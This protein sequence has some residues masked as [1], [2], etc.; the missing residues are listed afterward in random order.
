MG[1]CQGEILLSPLSYVMGEGNDVNIIP[2]DQELFC[3]L[4][5]DTLLKRE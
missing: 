1:L 3:L 5:F 2:S 4:A